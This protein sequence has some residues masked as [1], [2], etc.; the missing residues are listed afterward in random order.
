[1]VERVQNGCTNCLPS[2][3]R[4]RLGPVAAIVQ[5]ITSPGKE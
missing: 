4:G 2:Q 3:S 5:H 1:M